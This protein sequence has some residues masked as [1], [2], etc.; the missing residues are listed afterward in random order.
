MQAVTWL[1]TNATVED[2]GTLPRSR[3]ARSSLINSTT[4]SAKGKTQLERSLV[5][6]QWAPMLRLR[7]LCLALVTTNYWP[8]KLPT[9]TVFGKRLLP[10]EQPVKLTQ[11]NLEIIL[12]SWRF[13]KAKAAQVSLPSCVMSS[14]LLHSCSSLNATSLWSNFKMTT[15]KNTRRSMK[16]APLIFRW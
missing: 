11:I 12:I 5:S 9:L 10:I 1:K 3:R 2:R 6:S 15:Q 13:S 16:S 14:Y 8:T 4:T 7:T